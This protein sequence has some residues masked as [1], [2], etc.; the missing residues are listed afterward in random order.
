MRPLSCARLSVGNVLEF[1]CWKWKPYP[2]V[3]FRK[4][5]LVRALMRS[6]LLVDSFGLRPSNQYILVKVIPSCFRFAKMCLCQ[7]SLL[8]R[9]SPRY[10]TSSSRGKLEQMTRFYISFEWQ[11]LYFFFMYGAFTDRRTGL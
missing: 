6:L 7:V 2:R 9:C 8:S 4:S 1:L 10:L 11:L 5:I 3:V